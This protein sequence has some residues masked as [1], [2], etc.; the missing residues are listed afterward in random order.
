MPNRI[1]RDWTDSEKI[2]S[3]SVHAER[4]FV[5]LIMKVDDY[6]R[7]SGN[8]KLI[9]AN[10]Y[11]FLIDNI[12]ESDI[13]LWIT[14]CEKCGLLLVYEVE[15]KRYIQI[16]NFNQVLRQKKMRYPPP[17]IESEDD[18]QMTSRCYED[19]KQMTSRCISS[20]SLKRNETETETKRNECEVNNTFDSHVKKFVPPELS[21]F[22][23]YFKEN[24][25]NEELAT[26]AWK[27]YDEANWVDSN[28]KNIINWKQ[29]C[30]HVWFKNSKN[31]N[32]TIADK[33]DYK[34]GR[35]TRSEIEELL[36]FG[37]SIDTMVANR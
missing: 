7:Y 3:L 9:K 10:L 4:F 18:K 23:N 30:Q 11:P 8:L 14:E 34:I 16:N 1:L 29:K 20:A 22:V 36:N 27:G 35:N 26:R 17:I 19:D 33:T 25:F 6:G 21:E 32:Y 5:R 13:T 24:G 37:G 12:R 28:R 2:N 31:A 15:L